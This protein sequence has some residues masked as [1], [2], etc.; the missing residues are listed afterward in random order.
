MNEPDEE[1]F[2]VFYDAHQEKIFGFIQRMGLSFQDAEDAMDD[3]FLA[4]WRYWRKIEGDRLVY[5]YAIA[6]HAVYGRWNGHRRSPEDITS[7][8][9]AVT[10]RDFAQEVADRQALRR[11][12]SELSDR[13]REAVLFRYYIGLDVARTATVMDNISPGAVKRYAADGLR[14]LKRALGGSIT[15]EGG[16]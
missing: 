5:T 13:E 14:K 9:P 12:L 15:M 7:E 1:E 2:S 6:R 11:A 8:P 4:I 16:S 3:T 10:I